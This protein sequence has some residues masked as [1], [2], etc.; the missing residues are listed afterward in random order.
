[1]DGDEI[2]KAKGTRKGKQAHVTKLVNQIYKH[3]AEN[4]SVLSIITSKEELKKA[5]DVMEVA[6]EVLFELEP[7]NEDHEKW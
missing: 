2:R 5:V 7:E 4:V 1:M 6:N 3:L